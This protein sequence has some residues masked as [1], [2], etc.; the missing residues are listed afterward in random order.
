MIKREELLLHNQEC[1][2][3]HLDLAVKEIHEL[4]AQRPFTANK[5]PVIKIQNVS[6]NNISPG[7]YSSPYGY[8]MALKVTGSNFYLAL[9]PGEYDDTLEWPFQ[10]KVTVELLNQK[11]DKDH[12]KIAFSFNKY[13]PDKYK[14][15]VVPP[16]VNG[17]WSGGV[18]FHL[19]P[20]YT[21]NDTIY[22]R[23][24]IETTEPKQP[25]LV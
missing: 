8:K 15:R 17:E 22:F 10:G 2:S 18:D 19:S 21:S 5:I 23:V 7:F 13:T 3:S 25:W 20:D 12:R 14:N 24:S 4:R 11:E 6:Q 9:L 1:M 16:K